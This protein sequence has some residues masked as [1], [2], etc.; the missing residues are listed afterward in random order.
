MCVCPSGPN[1]GG[2]T[3]TLKTAGLAALMAKAG[4]FV[5]MEEQSTGNERDMQLATGMASSSIFPPPRTCR[6]FWFDQV[7]AS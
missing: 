6:M 1:T 2:K 3:V 4:L 7:L 5:P